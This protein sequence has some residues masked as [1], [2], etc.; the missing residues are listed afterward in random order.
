MKDF[1]NVLQT[2]EDAHQV[3]RGGAVDDGHRLLAGRALRRAMLIK[4]PGFSL[5][6]IAVLTLGIGGNAAVFSLF[7]GLALKPIPGVDRLR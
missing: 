7:K 1:G 4:N 6:V 2:Q 3:W 5:V